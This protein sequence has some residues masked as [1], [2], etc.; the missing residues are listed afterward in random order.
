MRQ[1]FDVMF[2]LCFAVPP[3]AVV[4]GVVALAWPRH[5]MKKAKAPRPSTRPA[6]A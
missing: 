6:H 3:I 2:V 4:A 1:I 5:V